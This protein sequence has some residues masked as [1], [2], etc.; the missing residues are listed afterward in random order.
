MKDFLSRRIVDSRG[1]NVRGSWLIRIDREIDR[2]ELRQDVPYYA[3]SRVYA[4]RW[5][6]EL[7]LALT[8]ET[9]R[10]M[11]EFLRKAVEAAATP[12]G[13]MHF[14]DDELAKE[15]P[16]LYD[17][18]ASK[19]GPNGKPREGAA[20]IA[21]ARDGEVTCS[22]KDRG[23]KRAWYGRSDGFRTALA[24]LESSLRHDDGQKAS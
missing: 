2:V 3:F 15:F 23:L 20:L 1:R 22:L 10:T 4:W 11:G 13:A 14:Q 17:F 18:L 16:A 12:E 21:Y 24:A 6:L 9:R 7:D 8:Y 19:I 5:A